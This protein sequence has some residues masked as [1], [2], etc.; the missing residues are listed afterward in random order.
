MEMLK[1]KVIEFVVVV[2]VLGGIFYSA[3]T[4]WQNHERL[5]NIGKDIRG[6]KESVLSLA[7]DGKINKSDIA[8]NL[9]TS[10]NQEFIDGILAYRS[11]HYE[12]A[13]NKWK[14]LKSEEAIQTITIARNLLQIKLQNSPN[15]D[16]D[17]EQL[18]KNHELY[19]DFLLKVGS[20]SED[21]DT[22]HSQI[23]EM[24]P[25]MKASI[26]PTIA[27]RVSSS[28]RPLQSPQAVLPYAR[29]VPQPSPNSIKKTSP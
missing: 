25:S 4:S 7:L 12:R 27:T 28:E 15:G 26:K 3:T 8:K 17:Y 24:S 23:Q 20:T 19:M 22:I 6:L 14:S 18:R 16:K 13:L 9:L 21:G 10:E 2:L 1:T 11:G 29:I 5:S